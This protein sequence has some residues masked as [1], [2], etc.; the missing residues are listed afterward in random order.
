MSANGRQAISV[1]F[2]STLA[3]VVCFAVWMMFA[4]IGIPIKESLKLS[5]A[6]FGLLAAT[7]VLTGALLRLPLGILTDRFGG[8]IVFFLLLLVLGRIRNGAL[9][10]TPSTKAENR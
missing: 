1:L 6:Q 5:D 2:A 3:F 8:R 4:I 9:L 10:T 7:P